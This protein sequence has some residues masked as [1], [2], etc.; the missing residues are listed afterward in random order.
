[1]LAH[2]E[3]TEIGWFVICDDLERKLVGGSIINDSYHL[4]PLPVG[5]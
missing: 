4:T 3:A 2:D 1:M 5:Q